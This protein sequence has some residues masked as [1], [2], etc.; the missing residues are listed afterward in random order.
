MP[1]YGKAGRTGEGR[2]TPHRTMRSVTR[3][4]AGIRPSLH[5]NVP[6][7][8]ATPNPKPLY[9]IYVLNTVLQP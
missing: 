5:S 7:E 8:Q 3:N 2:P 9:R 4:R 6:G 1:G